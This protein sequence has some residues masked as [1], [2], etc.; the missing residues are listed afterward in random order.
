[1]RTLIVAA[2]VLAAACARPSGAD[3][4]ASEPPASSGGAPAAEGQQPTLEFQQGQGGSSAGG[5]QGATATA[6]ERRISIQGT[7]QTPNPCFKLSGDLQRSG[8]VLTV[9]VT[10]RADPDG[11]CIQSIGAL[12]YTATVRGVA[13]GTY[14]VRVVH[15]YPD[16]GWPAATALETQVTIR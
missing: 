14:T 6:G 1:M 10:G 16:T 9:Q 8:Q 12:P 13:P 11:M 15:A 2:M 7:V 5:E 4:A 3:P